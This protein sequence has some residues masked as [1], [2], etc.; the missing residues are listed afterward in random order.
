M[1]TELLK[2]S[3][4]LQRPPGIYRY[5]PALGWMRRYRREYLIG[6]LIAGI[7]VAILLVPQ[8]MAYAMLGGLPPQVGLYASI[9][10]LVIYGLLGTSR[11]LAI[12]PVAIVSLLVAGGI[13]PIA[14]PGSDQYLQLA[15]SLALLVGLIQILMGI[16][17]L[18]FLV[19]FLSHPVLTGFTSGA[20]LLII[21]SQFKYLLG[22]SMPRTTNFYKLV[23]ALVKGLPVANPVTLGLGLGSMGLLLYFKHILTGQLRRESMPEP[24][25]LLLTKSGPVVVVVVGAWL[26]YVFDLHQQAQVQIV[27]RVPGGLPALHLPGWDWQIGGRLLPT[28]LAISFVSYMQS[29]SIGKWLASQSRQKLDTNQELIALGAANLIAPLAGGY[30][31]SGSFSRSMVNFTAGAKTGLATIITALLIGLT[32][33]FLTPLFYFL[34]QVALAAIILVTVANLIDIQTVRHMWRYN[35]ADAASLLITFA[36]VLLAGIE[37]GIGIGVAVAILL[38]LWRTSRPHI[39]ILGRIGETETYRNILRHQVQTCPRVIAIRVDES[40]YFAN[41]RY[42]EDVI[43]CLVADNPELEHLVLNGIAINFIDASALET[44]KSLK[45]KLD[46]AG[47]ELHLADIKGPVMDRLKMVGFTDIIGSD[48]IYLTTHEAMQALSCI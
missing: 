22:I 39:A 41:T 8:S 47:V 1:P 37:A 38:F 30:P 32:V 4:Y 12:G 24:L 17:R 6:D 42:L 36:G 34:P 2:E 21:L 25:W 20:A 11:A 29:I 46:N 15:L 44:L 27:G 40:L 28:A 10:P 3:P 16:I 13:G 7:I 19:N 45:E 31:I 14:E 26:V 18:G 23:P 35:K 43:L 9:L 5:L 33:L 48:H